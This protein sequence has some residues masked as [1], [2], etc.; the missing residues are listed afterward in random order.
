MSGKTTV[1]RLRAMVV[2]VFLTTYFLSGSGSK[3]TLT[4]V[5]SGGMRSVNAS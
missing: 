2:M 1:F 3:I 5:P 4:A